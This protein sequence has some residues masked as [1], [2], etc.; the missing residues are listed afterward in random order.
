MLPIANVAIV[1]LCGAMGSL[2]RY[3]EGQVGCISAE[4]GLGT[5]IVNV[6]GCFFIG[7]LYVLLSRWE[8][9]QQ[10][11]LFLMIGLLG[12]F[13]TFSSYVLDAVTMAQSG[14]IVR[15][16]GYVLLTNVLGLSAALLG[17]WVTSYIIKILG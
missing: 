1:A 2:L 8:F 4:K 12:G 16:I 9:S 7:V 17:L 3:I 11:R 14:E 6:S 5:F 10:W 13:T 15:S